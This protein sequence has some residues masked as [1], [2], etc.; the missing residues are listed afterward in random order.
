[1]KKPYIVGV[2]LGGTKIY[3]AVATLKGA[4]VSEIKIPTEA[5]LGKKHVINNIIT[6]IH[7]CIKNAGIAYKHISTVGIGAPGQIQYDAGIVLYAPHLKG[8][9]NVKLKKILEHKLKLPVYV[10]NDAQ[11][12]ALAETK[13]GAG[14]KARNLIYVTVSTGIG[15]GIII[16]RKIYYGHNGAAGE[17]G[18]VLLHSHNA[19]DIKDEHYTLE[20]LASGTGI[21]RK[22]QFEAYELGKRI[23]NKDPKALKALH[24]IIHYL[25]LSMANF[26]TILNPELIIVGGGLSSLGNTLMGPLRKEIKKKAFSVARKSVKIVRA[27]LRDRSGVLGAIALAIDKNKKLT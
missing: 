3:T 23:R 17:L 15:G 25:G 5:H 12:A 21:R 6:S 13:F 8:W 22:Y 11:L 19:R 18:H 7:S 4:V 16:D 2:D 1:M 26:T 24:R 20:Y 9:K 10:A 14:K 27:K